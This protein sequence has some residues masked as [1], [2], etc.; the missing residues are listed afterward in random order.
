VDVLAT[1]SCGAVWCVTQSASNDGDAGLVTGGVGQPAS[2]DTTALVSCSS[3][4]CAYAF[5]VTV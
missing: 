2:G 3:P 1:V 5:R 4:I